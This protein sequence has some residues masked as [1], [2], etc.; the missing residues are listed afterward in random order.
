MCLY[1]IDTVSY[2]FVFASSIINLYHKCA[3]FF[4]V[5]LFYQCLCVYMCIYYTECIRSVFIGHSSTWVV[6]F[7]F[8]DI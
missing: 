6:Y 1:S 8:M 3:A 7:D 4:F 5:H 2:M